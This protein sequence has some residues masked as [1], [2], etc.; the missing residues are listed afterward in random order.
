MVEELL[1]DI[2]EDKEPGC[3]LTSIDKSL[4]SHYLALAPEDSR[5]N[6]RTEHQYGRMEEAI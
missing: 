3:G 1:D 5:L 4:E 6:K 2:L